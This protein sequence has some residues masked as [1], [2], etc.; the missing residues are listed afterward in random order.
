MK[1]IKDIEDFEWSKQARFYWRHD[2]DCA[3]VCIADVEF[4]YCN[5]Y[6]GVKERLVI[7]PLTDRCYR[8]L[9][10]AL[11]LDLGGAP[12]LSLIHL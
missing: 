4:V 8:T 9:M 2:L 7:T 10:G 11:Q 6:L 5:E 3:K 1:K 12:M